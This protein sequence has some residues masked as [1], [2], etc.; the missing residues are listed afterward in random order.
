VTDTLPRGL[1]FLSASDGGTYDAETRTVTWDLGTVP[2]GDVDTLKLRARVG[3]A[4]EPGTQLI[5]R[6]D[7]D[8][9]A[10][11]SPPTAVAVT[12]VSP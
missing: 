7:F 4:A 5:N 10:T 1:R 9:I 3:Y 2:V 11:V 6:A 12:T 8:G